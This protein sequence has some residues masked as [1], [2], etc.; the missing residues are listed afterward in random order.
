MKSNAQM[1]QLTCKSGHVSSHVLDRVVK[2][3]GA[4]CGSCGAGL[5]Y[6]A[7][8]VARAPARPSK[9]DIDAKGDPSLRVVAA[10]TP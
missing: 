10:D 5:S 1:V 8:E 6:T 3:N 2:R 9:K 7:E 4:W